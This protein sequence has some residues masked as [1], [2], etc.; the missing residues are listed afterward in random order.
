M[1]GSN[2]LPD[3]VPGSPVGLVNKMGFVFAM[4]TFAYTEVYLNGKD[5]DQYLP[6]KYSDLGAGND[7]TYDPYTCNGTPSPSDMIGMNVCDGQGEDGLG[8]PTGPQL[9]DG[10]NCGPKLDYFTVHNH[11]IDIEIPSNAP[12]W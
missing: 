10:V 1:S 8:S 3:V 5:S 12:S 6:L 7:G 9:C 4:W 11:E 2:P